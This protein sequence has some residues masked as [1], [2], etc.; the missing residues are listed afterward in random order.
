MNALHISHGSIS[1]T[2]HDCLGMHKLT[3]P[4]VPKSLSDEQMANQSISIQCIV[5]AV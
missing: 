2:L 5:E 4:W 1:T 3:A